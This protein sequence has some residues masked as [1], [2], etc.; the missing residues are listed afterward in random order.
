MEI[1]MHQAFFSE[2]R[3][4]VAAGNDCAEWEE[5]RQLYTTFQHVFWC[6]QNCCN[7]LLNSC[8]LVFISLWCWWYS[9]L[10][11]AEPIGN[12]QAACTC[13]VQQYLSVKH[14]CERIYRK[15]IFFA[16][17]FH[18]VFNTSVTN[19]DTSH[20][21]IHNALHSAFTHTNFNVQVLLSHC[22]CCIALHSQRAMLRWKCKRKGKARK[23][24]VCVKMSHPFE[25]YEHT[26]TPARPLRSFARTLCH[27]HF[28]ML[29]FQLTLVYIL[30]N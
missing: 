9:A 14:E 21:K 15:A 20:Q 22:R 26:L 29:N 13:N 11:L 16:E 7:F 28:E 19:S 8:K 25:V 10:K 17:N 27:F 12:I 5:L 4:A 1:S 23:S 3:R 18:A 2:S 30:L 24:K 6:Y